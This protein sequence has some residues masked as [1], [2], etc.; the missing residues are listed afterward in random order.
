MIIF[1][2]KDHTD[3]HTSFIQVVWDESQLGKG[4]RVESEVPHNL[5]AGL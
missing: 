3:N 4:K 1:K 2:S 5:S